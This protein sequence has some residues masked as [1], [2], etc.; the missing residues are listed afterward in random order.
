M[1]RATFEAR[2]ERAEG[3]GTA[4]FAIAPIDIRDVFGKARPAVRVR[5]NGYTWRTTIAVYGGRSYVGIALQHSTAAGIAEGDVVTIDVESD[6]EPR[7]VTVPEDFAAALA[8][9]PGAAVRFEALPYT[10]RLEH[11]R[12]IE[13]AKRPETRARRIAAAIVRLR[14]PDRSR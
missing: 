7:T 14:Q 5:I 4:M 9:E 8:A 11:V 10:H 2:L 6:D 3:T 13:E 1:P 12:A